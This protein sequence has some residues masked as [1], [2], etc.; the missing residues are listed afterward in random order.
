MIF[1]F[2][3]R[4]KN[5]EEYYDVNS[6]MDFEL[7]KDR[8]DFVKEALLYSKAIEAGVNRELSN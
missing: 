1:Q 2:N 7:V 6:K 8:P 3:T 5:I 4:S